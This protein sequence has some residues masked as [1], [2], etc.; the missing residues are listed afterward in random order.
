MT[1]I[2]IFLNVLC[3]TVTHKVTSLETEQNISSTMNSNK[4]FFEF[5]MNNNNYKLSKKIRNKSSQF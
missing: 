5:K 3:K 1:R 4:K 2:N